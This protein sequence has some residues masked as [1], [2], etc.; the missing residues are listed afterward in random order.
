MK[1]IY[2]ITVRRCKEGRPRGILCDIR[3]C[4]YPSDEPHTEKEMIEKL[5]HF[6]LVLNPKSEKY[7]EEQYKSMNR[8]LPLGE[9]KN[10]IGIGYEKY[11]EGREDEAKR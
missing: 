6:V 9:F 4:G 8:W 2:Y 7:T 1:E 3:G 10:Q 11:S 5:G